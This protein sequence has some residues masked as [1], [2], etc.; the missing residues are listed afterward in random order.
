MAFHL[1]EAV[2]VSLTPIIR[3]KIFYRSQIHKQRDDPL[4]AY[5]YE[6]SRIPCEGRL[7]DRTHMPKASPLCVVLY[8][9]CVVMMS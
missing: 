2:Y 8:E 6:Q 3:Q 4:G 7:L 1:Y 5:V 9:V